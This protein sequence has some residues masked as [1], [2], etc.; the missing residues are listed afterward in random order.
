MNLEIETAFPMS[1]MHPPFFTSGMRVMDYSRIGAVIGHEITHA[2]DNSSKNLDGSGQLTEWWMGNT[3]SEYNKRAE[4]FIQQ[5]NEKIIP[6]IGKP[7]PG[8]QTLN[9]NIA[10][11]G[12]LREAYIAF[13][14]ITRSHRT[15]YQVGKKLYTAEQMFFISYGTG[16]CE[17]RTTESFQSYYPKMIHSPSRFRANVPVSNMPE[18]A[19][20]FKCPAGS[21]MVPKQRCIIW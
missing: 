9:E 11:N 1:L 8:A 3:L 2:F 13:K 5:Y 18:F 16:W 17:T 14:L 10:D 4:C 12:G 15:E 19:E 20:A 7:V 6:E 21:S